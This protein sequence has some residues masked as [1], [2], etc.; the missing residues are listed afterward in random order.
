MG[1]AH[2]TLW[3]KPAWRKSKPSQVKN[4]ANEVNVWQ[5]PK[6]QKAKMKMTAEPRLVDIEGISPMSWGSH[7]H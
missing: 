6:A 5:I 4:T 7:K 2:Q 1:C 3:T